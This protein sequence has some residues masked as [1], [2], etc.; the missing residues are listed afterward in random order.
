MRDVDTTL[1]LQIPGAL[2]IVG[3]IAL[4]WWLTRDMDERD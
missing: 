2:V 4:G 1:L 3:F